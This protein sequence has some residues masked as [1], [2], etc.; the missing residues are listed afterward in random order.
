MPIFEW[1]LGNPTDDEEGDMGEIMQNVG[2]AH[3]LFI[4]E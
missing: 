2:H 4:E 1:R 3:P